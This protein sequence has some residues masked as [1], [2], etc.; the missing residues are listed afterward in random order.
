MK[1]AV[2]FLRHIR[3]TTLLAAL[4]GMFAL[5]LIGCTAHEPV[6]RHPLGEGLI[7]K[8]N[9]E[10]L[11][12]AGVPI[13]E[14]NVGDGTVLS[15][16]QEASMFA[17]SFVGSKASKPLVH[18]GCWAHVMLSDGQVTGVEFKPVPAHL[19][20]AEPCEEIFQSCVQ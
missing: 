10:L 20:T 6:V 14:T 19:E 11:A 16:Y 12:C 18:G 2:Q 8:S 1:Q 9:Q 7:G 3:S 5:W 4:N 15:Y 13:R 17:E